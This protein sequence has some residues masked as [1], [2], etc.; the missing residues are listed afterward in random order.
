MKGSPI[1]LLTDFGNRDPYV[2]AVKGSIYRI[3]PGAV[4]TDVSHHVPRHDTE[5]AAYHLLCVERYFPAGTIF[6]CIVD[7]GV[8]SGRRIIILKLRGRTF[9]APDNGILNYLSG[10]TDPGKTYS[11]RYRDDTPDV[12][13]TFHGR[14]LF[15]PAAARLARGERISSVAAASP[16]LVPRQLFLDV[17]PGTK[18]PVAGKILHID[19]FGNIITNLKI[20]RFGR[21]T[22]SVRIGRKEIRSRALSYADGTPAKPFMLIGSTGLLEISIKNGDATASLGTKTGD[23]VLFT[24][25]ARS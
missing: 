15:A 25:G 22:S 23:R 17:K 16:A 7:P 12:S 3:H 20:P 9:I 11:L 19:H 14:D 2:A 6:V 21:G 4:I 5:S 18:R 24:Q 10:R 8:G 1:A 13:R